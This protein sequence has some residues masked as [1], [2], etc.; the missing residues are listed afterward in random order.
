MGK[1]SRDWSQIYAIY[2]MDEW[3]TFLFLFFHALIFSLLS[4]L[5][6]HY[7]GPVTA[8]LSLLKVFSLL[9][10]GSARFAAGLMGSI[11]ALIAVCLL[12][13]AANFLYSAVPLRWEISQ[14]MLSAVTDWSNVKTALDVGCGRGILL[15]A[16]ALQLKKQGSSGRVVG[17]DQKRSITLRTLR[18]ASLEGV[19]EY[20]TCR[21]GDVR[22]LPF[23][24]DYFDVVVSGAA[25]RRAGVREERE[26]VVGE[27]VRVLKPGGVGV[28]WDLQHVPEYVRRLQDLRMEEIRV[29]ERVTAYMV[30]SHIVSFRKPCYQQQQQLQ[31]MVGPVYSYAGEVRL[32]WRCHNLC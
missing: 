16:V 4:V 22:K 3:Q 20:V 15:N 29:S 28:V 30:S 2:G 6:L 13:A 19:Q 9:P 12:F 14:R 27:M 1:G 18:T 5:I 21:E 10:P 26:R 24:D 32:D 25:I 17:L 7:F 23:R 8:S 31:H 11:T